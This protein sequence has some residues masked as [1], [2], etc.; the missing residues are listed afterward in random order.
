MEK[1]QTLLSFK[2]GG[3]THPLIPGA[4]PVLEAAN[5]AFMFPDVYADEPEAAVGIV[6]T[7]EV[8]QEAREKLRKMLD[9]LTAFKSQSQL[10]ED[11]R[12]GTIGKAIVT[13]AEYLGKGMEI[14]ATKAC[15]LIEYVGEKQKGKMEPSSAEEE[16]AKINPALKYSVK[17]AAYATHATVKV[18]GF[19]AKRVGKLTK[20]LAN[21]MASKIQKPVS[22]AIVGPEGS[23]SGP[24]KSVSLHTLM[25]AAHGG[26]IAYGTVYAALEESAKTLGTSLKGQSVNVV[27]H[28]YGNEAGQ[29]YGE[30]MTA[31]GNAAM[32]YLN[33]SS[34]GVKGLVKRTAKDTAKG[35]AK[36]V[37]EAHADGKK[38]KIEDQSANG[39]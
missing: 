1:N 28:K 32:T 38:P 34:L 37:I 7:D 12:L 22:G 4:S 19:V 9:E 29:V 6:L 3:W 26:L 30:A 35:V 21:Y 14:G 27:Q 2:V 8:K 13:G 20:G 18:S 15:E 25:D 16:D 33:V 11:Q 39:K 5:G 23:S 10:P 24:K 17:G 31:A 36:G